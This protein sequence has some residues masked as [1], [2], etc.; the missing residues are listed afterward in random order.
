M[1]GTLKKAFTQRLYK[2]TRE[3]EEKPFKKRWL[4]EVFGISRQGYYKRMKHLET[5][6][7]Q[8]ELILSEVRKIRKLQP[9]YGT[10]KVFKELSFFFHQQGIKMGR[11][12]FFKLLKWN[13]MLVKKSKNFIT[14]T[15]SKHRFFKSPNRI[16]DLEIKQSEQV[17]VSD[18]TYV[19]LQNDYAYLALVTDAYS[20]KI[21]GFNIDNHMRTELVV[22]ALKMALKERSFP[23]RKIIHHSDRGIQYCSPEFERYTLKNDIILSNTQNSDPYENAVA[24]RMNKTLKYEYGLKETL[25]DLKTAQKMTQQAV[26]LYNNHRLHFSLNFQTPAKVHLK[27]NVKYKSYK[28]KKILI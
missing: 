21:V 20:K 23:D 27:E 10:L 18:I 9:K 15:N 24:E 6:S 8:Y 16:L 11:D 2:R 22:N 4:A 28:R 12:R 26:N 19:K 25:P 13:G 7:H 5:Q 17:W 1:Q 3:K 14:T